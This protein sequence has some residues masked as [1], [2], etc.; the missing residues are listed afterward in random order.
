[1]IV[2]FK[3]YITIPEMEEEKVAYFRPGA[4]LGM[5][6]ISFVYGESLTFKPLAVRVPEEL[7][8]EIQEVIER[9]GLD[10]ATAVRKLLELCIVE[11]RKQ[12]ALICCVM[13]R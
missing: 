7:E 9:E 6:L 2:T 12:T 13:E 5:R 3:L 11:W 8:R 4:T 1:M 10:K